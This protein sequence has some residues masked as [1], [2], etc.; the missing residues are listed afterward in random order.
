MTTVC[1]LS[2]KPVQQLNTDLKIELKMVSCWIYATKFKFNMNKTN[3][4]VIKGRNNNLNVNE[5]NVEHL[6]IVRSTI[7]QEIY[8]YTL[9][10][11][12]VE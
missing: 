7:I 11:I 10:V 9:L 1:F 4:M 12:M 6:S 2:G 3:Y 5:F 8:I